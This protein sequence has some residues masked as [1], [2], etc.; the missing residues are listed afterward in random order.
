MI[1]KC[2]I[3]SSNRVCHN[4]NRQLSVILSKLIVKISFLC[5]NV[6]LFLFSLGHF[7]LNI[8]IKERAAHPMCNDL[9]YMNLLTNWVIYTVN[10]FFMIKSR[11]WGPCSKKNCRLEW[12]KGL[13]RE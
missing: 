3:K 9:I 7:F 4:S 1:I 13:I 5:T 11:S 6:Y 8:Y 12:V 10:M 2:P